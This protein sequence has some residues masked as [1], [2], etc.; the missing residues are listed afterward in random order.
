MGGAGK[1][2]A[3]L[4][5]HLANGDVLYFNDMAAVM[6][7]VRRFVDVG[8]ATLPHEVAVDMQVDAR[9]REVVPAL[10]GQLC[11]H[12]LDGGGPRLPGVRCGALRKARNAARH[13]G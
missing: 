5:A 6:L 1:C 11:E 12:F 3:P 4:V 7:I 13:A 8:D 10:R 9:I 2:K